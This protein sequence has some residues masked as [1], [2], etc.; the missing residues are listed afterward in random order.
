MAVV[1]LGAWVQA[2]IRERAKNQSARVPPSLVLRRFV[3][4]LRGAGRSQGSFYASSFTVSV[5]NV[6]SQGDTLRNAPFV[7]VESPDAIHQEKKEH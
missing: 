4:V 3:S 5:R 1:G 2:E 7:S 6:S